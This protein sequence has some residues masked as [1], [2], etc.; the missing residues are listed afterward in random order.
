[1]S[2]SQTACGVSDHCAK[3]SGRVALCQEDLALTALDLRTSTSIRHAEYYLAISRPV[4]I[5]LTRLGKGEDGIHHRPQ[6]PAVDQ[7][8]DLAKLCPIRLHDEERLAHA[9]VL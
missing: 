8:G 1:K 5:G 6:L 9:G 7:A 3:R 2:A 4:L